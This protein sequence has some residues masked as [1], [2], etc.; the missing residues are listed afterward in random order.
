MT[1]L[2]EAEVQVTV[3]ATQPI[4]PEPMQDRTLILGAISPD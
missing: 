1:G 2:R 4:H 3:A